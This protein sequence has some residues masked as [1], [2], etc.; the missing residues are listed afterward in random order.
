MVH[1]NDTLTEL[2]VFIIQY[3]F[4]AAGPVWNFWA[5]AT[6]DFRR[7]GCQIGGQEVE[8]VASRAH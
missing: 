1:V 4:A 6:A 3:A 7:T 2:M 5:E 8:R